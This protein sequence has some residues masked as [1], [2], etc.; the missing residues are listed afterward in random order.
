LFMENW[1]LARKWSGPEIQSFKVPCVE[2]KRA[3][4]ESIL[5]SSASESYAALKNLQ[6][7]DTSAIEN[8][9]VM[10]ILGAIDDFF[11][12]VHPRTLNRSRL[13]DPLPLTHWLRKV[14][15]DRLDNGA[16]SST[17]T[18]QLVPRGPLIR[19]PRGEFA[20]SAYSLAD[21][22]AFLTVV[23]TELSIDDR[24]IRVS[25]IVKDRSLSQGIGLA[26]SSNG[27]E[28]I[29]FIPIAQLDEHLQINRVEVNGHAYVDFKLNDDVDAAAVIN[30]VL[31]DIGYADI[32]MSAELMVDAGAADRL[33]PLISAIPGRTR[34][35][36]AG[37]GNTSDTRDGLPWNEARIFNGSGVEL[38]RQRK[39]WQAGLDS[40]RSEDL[41]LVPGDNGRLMEHNHA[42]EE[43]VVAD[44]DGFGRC[45]VLIC[46]DIQSNPL[47][48]ELI[49]QYQPDWVF[50]PILDWGA[51]VKR[52]AHQRVFELSAISPARFLIASSLSMVEKLK[53][54]EQPCGLAIGPKDSTDED[55]G[56]ECATAYAKTSPH[57]YGIVEWR[58]GWGKSS[59]VFEP[60]K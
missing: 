13:F 32:V 58:T 53:R 60:K 35:L 39:M 3:V 54:E 52:W 41:G 40:S 9:R 26:P 2:F 29:A 45:V 21:Q 20:S 19:S 23:R 18:H 44:V 33:S 27:S 6:R 59:L 8:G 5:I 14:A 49:R 10:F 1:D 46:Q 55:Q 38:W 7:G 16:F 17:A 56:R 47:A 42:G 30:S 37:S 12:I 22:F 25:T 50:V 31:G 34:I 28:K 11:E 57:G 43:I 15:L 4:S 36:L 51:G 24:P 48:S